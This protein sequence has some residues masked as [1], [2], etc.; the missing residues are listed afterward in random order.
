[1]SL[2]L[3]YPDRCRVPKMQYEIL[4]GKN[5]GSGVRCPYRFRKASASWLASRWW[6]STDILSRN[7]WP[8]QM[9]PSAAQIR[10]L[11]CKKYIPC[12]SRSSR[13][14]T[15]SGCQVAAPD[16]Q[17]FSWAH[18]CNSRAMHPLHQT[19]CGDVPDY[20]ASK[21]YVI[22]EHA[23]IAQFVLSTGR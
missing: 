7:A 5:A 19:Q 16:S 6:K 4:S 9:C 17:T 11:H 14:Y 10:D 18:D 15:P 13:S 8:T 12:D 3:E 22:K 20:E 1:M 23:F 2:G 21:T